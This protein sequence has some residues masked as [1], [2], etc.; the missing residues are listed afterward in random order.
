MP[1]GSFDLRS[2]RAWEYPRPDSLS[3]IIVGDMLI[4][5]AATSE[6][7][8]QWLVLACSPIEKIMISRKR[9]RLEMTI[10]VFDFNRG[11]R[12]YCLSH[13]PDAALADDLQYIKI[14]SRL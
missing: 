6:R 14:V 8:R 11:I 1:E 4:W 3:D 5:V 9:I 12:E 7:S 13:Y 10:Q 2:F